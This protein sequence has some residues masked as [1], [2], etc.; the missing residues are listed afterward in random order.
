VFG[1][2]S[3]N[4]SDA[5]EHAGIN[6]RHMRTLLRKYGILAEANE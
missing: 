1:A 4:I 3:G 5:A 2:A 6:R